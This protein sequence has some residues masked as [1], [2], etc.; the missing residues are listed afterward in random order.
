VR[1]HLQFKDLPNMRLSTLKRFLRRDGF[2]EHLELHRLDCLG[3]HGNLDNWRLAFKLSNELGPEEIRPPRLLTG[4]DLI[5]MGFTPGKDFKQM[6]R[7]VEDAQ[8]DGLIRTSEQARQWILGRYDSM[9][10]DSSKKDLTA[11]RSSN[12][13]C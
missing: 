13:D 5:A 3:S 6:L 9:K 11:H 10:V 7:V 12:D 1:D 4:D 2:A 8:L